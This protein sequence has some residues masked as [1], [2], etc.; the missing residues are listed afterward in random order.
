VQA[1]NGLQGMDLHEFLVTPQ[2]DA[3]IV[4]VSPVRYPGT[5]KPLMDA[6]VQEIDIKTGLVLFEWHALD[7]VPITE[8]YFNTKSKGFVFDPYHLNS[9]AV[10]ADGNLILSM[11]NTWAVYKVN[12]STGAVMWTL[13]SNKSNFK[14]GS[15]TSTAFQHDAIVQPDG[16]I[17]MFDDGGGPPTVRAGRASRSTRPTTRPRCSTSTSTTR[18]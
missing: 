8:S 3:Y 18:P 1:A 7:H 14:M 6:V 15:G 10:D 12:R 17:T 9:I 16:S 4:G 11:R 5:S 2:G 13:G